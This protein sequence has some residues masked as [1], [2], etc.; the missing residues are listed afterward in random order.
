[1]RYYSLVIKTIVINKMLGGFI[2]YLLKTVVGIFKT[3][4]LR[5]KQLHI[6]YY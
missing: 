6:T 1:M 4:I 3:T 5:S 2:K